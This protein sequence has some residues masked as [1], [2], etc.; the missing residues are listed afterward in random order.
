MQSGRLLE[1]L[2]EPPRKPANDTAVQI[3]SRRIPRLAGGSGNAVTGARLAADARELTAATDG[4]LTDHLAT[5]LATYLFFLGGG[6]TTIAFLPAWL[7]ALSAWVPM[8]Y[9]ID[10]MRQALFYTSLDGIR[11]DLLALFGTALVAVILG[12]FVIRQRWAYMAK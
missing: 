9:A 10:G 3:E 4:K 1:S 5:V 8:R 12:A 7:R 6:F 2:P 11:E